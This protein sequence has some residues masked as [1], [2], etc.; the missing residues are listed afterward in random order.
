MAIKLTI[1][2]GDET[3]VHAAGCADLRKARTRAEA[4]NGYITISFPEG[5]DERAIW[6]DHN[7]DFLREAFDMGEEHPEN[8][9]WPLTFL[10]CSH[11]AGVVKNPDR[12]WTEADQNA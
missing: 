12:T 2:V 8:A 11:E 10:P 1:T 3:K 6:I 7:E 4:Y 9:A 5:T